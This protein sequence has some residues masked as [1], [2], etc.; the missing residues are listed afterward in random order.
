[1]FSGV[2][3][4]Y[5]FWNQSKKKISMMIS[6]DGLCP[7]GWYTEGNQEGPSCEHRPCRVGQDHML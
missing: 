2:S 5:K 3:E 7:A 6:D 1:M 4:P